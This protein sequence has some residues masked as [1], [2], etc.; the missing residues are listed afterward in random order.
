M[1]KLFASLLTLVT[2]SVSA[3]T[4]VKRISFG[5]CN[6]QNA[7]QPLWKDILKQNPDLFIWAGDTVYAD[8]KSTSVIKEAY[9]KQNKNPDYQEVKSRIPIIG[10]WDDHD[11]AYD[12]AGG[13]ISFKKESQKL[14]LDFIG[15]PAN[16]LRRTQSGIYTSK[17]YRSEGRKIKV[18]LLDNRYF[19]GLEGSAMILGEAQWQWLEDELKNSDASLHFIVT[20]LSVF[21]PLL[22]YTEEWAETYEADRM[23]KVLNK[24]QPKG[25]LF[26]TGDK[27][28]SSIFMRRDQLEFMGSGMTHTVDRRIVRWYASRYYPTAYFGL[29]Y[30][31]V[32]ISWDGDTPILNLAVRNRYDR[33]V[34]PSKFVWDQSLG[35]WIW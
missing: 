7:P 31:Q 17:V 32:D 35:K 34:F 30:G 8:R 21:S 10:T 5:S 15:E 2:L 9:E 24:Y 14:F 26:L 4:N 16:S 29:S 12:N 20:G 27:H 23:L 1:F 6:D 25:V 13:S 3:Q 19:K 28:F 18:I 33:S 22:P 11:Y